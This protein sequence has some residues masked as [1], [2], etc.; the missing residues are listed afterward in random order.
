[1]YPFNYYRPKS[2]DEAVESFQSFEEAQWL[3]GG[4]TLLPSLKLR[5]AAP[6]ALID[7]NFIENLRGL[8]TSGGKI[9]IGAMTRHADVHNSQDIKRTIPALS[10]LAGGI[11]DSQVRNRGTIGGSISNNDPAADYPA[12]ILGLNAAVKTNKRDIAADDF[13]TGMFETSLEE[14]EIIEKIIVPVP[15]V[16][17]YAKFPHP[18]SGYAVSAVMVARF[19]KDVRVAVAGTASCVFRLREL[20]EALAQNFVPDAAEAIEL[21]LADVN[22]DLHASAEYRANLTRVMA[23]R[24]IEAAQANA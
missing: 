16:A 19:G 8:N 20:E 12:A 3:A 15:D 7:L 24:A 18:A 10:L 22:N 4:M 21:D 23:R 1:M 9:S 6:G 5:L 2:I 17:G 14:G 11:G 13:F